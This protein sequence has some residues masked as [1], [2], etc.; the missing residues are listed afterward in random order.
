MLDFKACQSV[1][2]NFLDR[3]IKNKSE[4]LENDLSHYI[5]SSLQ[6]LR[7]NDYYTYEQ[8]E[9]LPSLKQKEVIETVLETNSLNTNILIKSIYNCNAPN[10]E[11]LSL[12]TI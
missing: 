5:M 3:Y 8:L 2:K 12:F 11:A 9:M 6:D 10:I 4:I 7:N 1:S